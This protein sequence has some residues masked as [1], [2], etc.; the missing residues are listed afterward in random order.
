MAK[1][2][3][4]TMYLENSLRR[5]GAT[6]IC[7]IDEVG[8][9]SLAGPL[10]VGAVILPAGWSMALR[11]SKLLTPAQRSQ[12]AGY[13]RINSLG[14]GLGWV[15]NIEIDELGLTQATSLACERALESL[16]MAVSLVIMDGNYDYLAEFGVTQTLVGADRRVS[17]VAAASIIAKVARDGYMQELNI[18]YPQ[19]GWADNVGYG[20]LA[21]RDAMAEYGLTEIHRK[22]FCKKYI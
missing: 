4:A 11:D 20:T 5:A 3:K 22:K 13:I 10:V 15:D 9:G 12:L 21:H 19:Y 6:L 1:L 14:Y 8:R 18:Q 7:G 17:C 2:D 16:G